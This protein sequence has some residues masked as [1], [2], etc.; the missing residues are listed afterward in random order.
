MHARHN[1][2]WL[3]EH[4]W[5]QA[6]ETV[7]P[8]YR[9]HAQ[10]WAGAGRPAIVRRADA[11]AAEHEVCLGIALPPDPESG[12]KTRIP[13][14]A[15]ATDIVR[16]APPL[17]LDTVAGIFHGA[18]RLRLQSL[19]CEAADCGVL[20]RVFGS[21][22]L[23][24]LTGERYLTATSDIDLL[25]AP[26]D[27]D[28]LERGL[29]LLDAYG[30]ALPLDG[31]IVFPSGEAVAWKEWRNATRAPQ[32]VRVLVKGRNMVYLAT[33]AGLLSTLGNA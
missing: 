4:G 8:A 27:Y 19:A 7:P 12:V 13:L 22:A 5:R 29:A 1:L 33:T 30:H 2:A 21:V 20:L 23:Q 9:Q 32:K 15:H 3:S 6:L 17:S 10:A 24:V 28:Q 11:D 25:F 16:L 18:R 26:T 14:R 31:E